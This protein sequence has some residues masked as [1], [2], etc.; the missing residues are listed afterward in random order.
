MAV[1]W[2]WVKLSGGPMY[3]IYYNETV[4]NIGSSG[5]EAVRVFVAREVRHKHPISHM[6]DKIYPCY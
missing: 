3:S 4:E 5:T 2:A 1:I 6:D